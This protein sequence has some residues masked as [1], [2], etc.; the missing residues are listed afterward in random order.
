MFKI[1]FFLWRKEGMTPSEFRDYYEQRHAKNNQKVRPASADYRRNYP[2]IND[3]WTDAGGLA[4]L[5]GFDVMSENSYPDRS[6]HEKVLEVMS[7]SPEAPLIHE[8]E[9]KFEIR[10]KK[11]VF[12]CREIPTHEYDSSGYQMAAIRN[13]HAKFK[14]VRYV[15]RAD[16]LTPAAFEDQY[17]GTRVPVMADIFSN[18]LDYRR[19]YL[20]FE[21][22][23]TFNGPQEKPTPIERASFACDLVEQIWYESRE[24]AKVDYAR[25][26]DSVRVNDGSRRPDALNSPLVVVNEYRLPRPETLSW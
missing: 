26:L 22:P 6:R 15:H 17:E 7:R 18:S 16:G 11:K 13:E 25:F 3:P 1:I 4:R 24:A 10:D 21:D 8:D 12:V 23:L 14:L 20:L 2:M 19:N 5:G 9:A